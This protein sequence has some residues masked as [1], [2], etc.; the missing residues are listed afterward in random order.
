MSRIDSRSAGSVSPTVAVLLA[1]NVGRL[2]RLHLGVVKIDTEQVGPKQSL[3]STGGCR[4]D[5][6]SVLLPHQDVLRDDQFI[7]ASLNG[8][9]DLFELRLSSLLLLLV[10][11]LAQQGMD[12]RSRGQDGNE[13]DKVGVVAEL[14]EEAFGGR[15]EN[16]I[17]GHAAL[18]EPPSTLCSC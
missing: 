16:A 8:L 17:A 3:G 6:H 18:R 14:V 15:V 7:L 13:R 2:T 4:L 9:L 12:F 5:I 10:S 11:F 1:A